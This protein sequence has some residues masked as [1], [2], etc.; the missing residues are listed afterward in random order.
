MTKKMNK[1]DKNLDDSAPSGAEEEEDPEIKKYY[2]T[3]ELKKHLVDKQNRV[4]KTGKGKFNVT[5]PVP[6]EFMNQEKGF[7]IRQK[8]VE[9]MIKE[10]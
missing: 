8:K 1:D 2:L 5:V 4:P 3:R 7:S 10:K 9:Q 6:F